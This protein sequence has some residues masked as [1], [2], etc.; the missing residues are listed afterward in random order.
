MLALIGIVLC[1]YV[2]MRGMEMALSDVAHVAVRMLAVAALLAAAIGVIV[3]F[4]SARGEVIDSLGDPIPPLSLSVTA[5]LP[6]SF[7]PPRP[8]PLASPPPLG[9]FAPVRGS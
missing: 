6:D 8:P 3:L 5:A 7:S 2:A 9:T 4:L 1:L